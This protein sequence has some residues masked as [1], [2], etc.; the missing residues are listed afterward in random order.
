MFLQQHSASHAFRSLLFPNIIFSNTPIL[1]TF[2]LLHHSS[3]S[4][5]VLVILAQF[6]SFGDIQD[7]GLDEIV[8]SRDVI[9]L[10]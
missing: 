6:K 10:F 7:G 5:L 4:L 3:I 2:A 9:V 8:T 1:V